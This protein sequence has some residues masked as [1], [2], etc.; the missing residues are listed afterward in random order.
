MGLLQKNSV[1]R[2]W[3]LLRSILSPIYQLWIEENLS[4]LNFNWNYYL[5]ENRRGLATDT[6]KVARCWLC[7]STEFEITIASGFTIARFTIALTGTRHGDNF[8]SNN[9]FTLI[10][11]LD[12]VL[13]SQA[14]VLVKF[15]ITMVIDYH[16]GENGHNKIEKIYCKIFSFAIHNTKQYC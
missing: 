15:K 11:V 1:F 3:G 12:L 10:Y 7:K 6:I 2:V 13:S 16:D 4:F 8:N 14:Q 5:D 9:K